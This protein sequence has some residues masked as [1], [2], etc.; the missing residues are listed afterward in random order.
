MPLLLLSSSSI[1]LQILPAPPG[2]EALCR[3]CMRSGV[4]SCKQLPPF[5]SALTVSHKRFPMRCIV[6]H[7]DL[8]MHT[9]VVSCS[10]ISEI[11]GHLALYRTSNRAHC[12]FLMH[13]TI[14]STSMSSSDSFHAGGVVAGWPHRSRAEHE[15]GAAGDGRGSGPA[16]SCAS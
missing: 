11:L 9:V 4:L 2:C 10:V 8:C 15:R 14:V 12:N 13:N 7:E 1:T 3:D 6:E 16:S 5:V